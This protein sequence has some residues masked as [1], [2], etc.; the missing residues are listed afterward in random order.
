MNDIIMKHVRDITRADQV[1]ELARKVLTVSAHP[2][3]A[4]RLAVRSLAV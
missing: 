3:T 2:A 4:C 1:D